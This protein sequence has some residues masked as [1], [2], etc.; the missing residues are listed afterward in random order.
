[1]ISQQETLTEIIDAMNR[2]EFQSLKKCSTKNKK[3]IINVVEVDYE[4]MWNHL[5]ETL[6]ENIK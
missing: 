1:M 3:S 6:K 2:W 5:R 4:D